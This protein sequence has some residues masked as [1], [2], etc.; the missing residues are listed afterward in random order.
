M[1]LMQKDFGLQNPEQCCDDNADSI[2]EVVDLIYD[3]IEE[4]LGFS[5]RVE[6]GQTIIPDVDTIKLGDSLTLNPGQ[7]NRTAIIQVAGGGSGISPGDPTATVGEFPIPGTLDTY[8]R[9]DAAPK[10][11]IAA[12]T[13]LGGVRSGKNLPITLDGTLLPR[14]AIGEFAGELPHGDKAIALG[15]QAGQNNQTAEGI[16]IGT[17]AGQNN[18]E[19]A[20][21]IG[22]D[23]G[24]NV[25]ESDTIAI[26]Y[27][28]G[29]QSQGKLA[30]A[31]GAKSGNDSQEEVCVAV[32]P[33][34][35]A[36]GQKVASTAVGS[37]AGRDDQGIPGLDPAIVGGA[38]AMGNDAGR[39][40]QA[41]RS[42]AIGHS[43][44]KDVQ[45]QFCVAIGHSAGSDNQGVASS[46]ALSGG[47]VA[48]GN[49]AGSDMQAGKTVAVGDTSGS[50]TQG[51]L[52][53]AIGYAAGR[54]Q[55]GR[56]D[57]TP[58]SV[59]IGYQS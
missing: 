42:V 46:Q 7:D 55:Q 52:C 5:L 30:I 35:G 20:I 43:A 29:N 44:G 8:M 54:D 36:T 26:G 57:E 50:T 24:A 19:R 4:G 11:Q 28:A 48:V 58:G 39:T 59:A 40:S 27:T 17:R 23:A 2:G 21:A 14:L 15:V 51:L 53:V 37:N 49:G 31:I 6:D 9:S 56:N 34:A 12:E 13:V 33:Y 1:V 41:V 10:L 25:Q 38:V 18:Q 45:K 32:G 22:T 16:A 3:V 47:S